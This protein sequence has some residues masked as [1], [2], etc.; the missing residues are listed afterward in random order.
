MQGLMSLPLSVRH[1][2]YEFVALSW[3]PRKEHPSPTHAEWTSWDH[4]GYYKFALARRPKNNQQLDYLKDAE[5][6]N[7]HGFVLAL[8][9]FEG[10]EDPCKSTMR[11][12]GALNDF[13]GWFWDNIV[14]YVHN[15]E[16][17][18]GEHWPMH[19][20][21]NKQYKPR[22]DVSFTSSLKDMLF[23]WCITN[24]LRENDAGISPMA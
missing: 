4:H 16:T 18:P 5:Y 14:M 10:T 12:L 23:V 24:I 21:Y 19:R 22:K 2:I 15:V 13:M 3:C 20:L 9:K 1:N 17:L 8:E 7:I 11:G 6:R